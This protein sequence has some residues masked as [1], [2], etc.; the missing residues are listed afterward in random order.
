MSYE[1]IDD[2]ISFE[3]INI[4]SEL[5]ENHT[6]TYQQAAAG[7]D[8]AIIKMATLVLNSGNGLSVDVAIQLYRLAANLGNAKA[9]VCAVNLMR[10][11]QNISDAGQWCWL[12]LTRLI[13]IGYFKDE[14][15]SLD[16]LVLIAQQLMEYDPTGE[17][18]DFNELQAV[19][20][21]VTNIKAEYAADLAKYD[22]GMS[23]KMKQAIQMTDSGIGSK[24]DRN[25]R[26]SVKQ[27][28]EMLA[29]SA[30]AAFE[31]AN[32]Y[33]TGETVDGVID[34][35][36]AT[37]LYA[38]SAIDGC[39]DAMPAHILRLKAEFNYAEA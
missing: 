15:D 35:K 31:L 9:M 30:G 18:I 19:L 36:T 14:A 29:G 28:T 33:A 24:L 32:S 1:A 4:P 26:V 27:Y 5:L 39:V 2:T 13:T 21:E 16:S 8:E 17:F 23:E 12:Y 11:A 22:Y 37:I 25:V 34:L 10:D 38:I 20:A 3:D 7:D 6:D